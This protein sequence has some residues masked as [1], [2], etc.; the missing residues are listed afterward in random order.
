GFATQVPQFAGLLGLSA[1]LEMAVESAL[2]SN[3]VP[4][5]IDAIF[6]VFIITFVLGI[7]NTALSYGGF[8]ARRRGGRIEVERGLISRQS[9]GVAITRVQSV[10]ITQGF[11][12]RLIGYGQ[13]K[14]LTIDSMTPEQQQNAAQ[15]PTG[16]VV[17]PFV[18]MDRIDGILAQLLPEFDERPQPSEYKTLPKVA[19]RRV[20]NR[21]TVLTA[22]P[23]AVF[24]LVATIVLQ[25]IPTP[26]A[27]DPFTGWIIALLWT[28]LVLIIIG[29]S[30][31]AIFWY[32][33]AAYS[34][35][36]TM[37]LIRQGFYGRVT[38]IIPR[39]KIQWAR[40]HQNPI[41][42]MSKVANIT[43]VTAAGVTGT[44]TTL[45]DLDAEEASAYLDWVRPHKGSQNPEA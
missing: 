32:K 44:K 11:I 9:R 10:E 20:V 8:K 4:V 6:V 19:F 13:L 21:H 3:F 24:A 17:H 29:R 12:R 26:P 43:A 1:P 36:K 33:N 35:N 27:F 41:Q 7:L 45:R 37:L 34:Y 31:G 40:T 25:V 42:K 2:R 30:I 14:L 16:L 38:T 5:L 18:K 39:N 22:I 23:Y 15:I 28:I